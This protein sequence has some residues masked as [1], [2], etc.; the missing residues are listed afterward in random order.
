MPKLVLAALFVLFS[1]AQPQLVPD[2]PHKCED[3]PTWNTP[4]EPFQLFGNSYYV[5]TDGLSAVLVTGDAGH[6]LL[7]AGLS[8]SAA[9]IDANIRK[10]GFKTTDVKLILVSHGHFDHAGGVAALQRFTEA[11]VAASA[12]TADALRRGENTT[13]DPQFGFGQQFNGFP[14][15]ARVQALRDRETVTIGKIQITAHMIPGHAP[16]SAAYTWRSCVPFAPA[17]GTANAECLNMAYVDSVT[18]P[19]A[20]G[21]KYGKPRLELF[22]RSL[23]KVA[24]LPCDIIVS[25]HPSFTRIDEKLRRRAALNGQGPDPFVDPNGCKAYA[26][27]GLKRLEARAAEEAK[28]GR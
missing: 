9:L 17:T 22:R 23:E 25:P 24:G 12:S 14:P 10:L 16:G 27:E 20:P 18:L 19:S 21:F 6:I 26:A 8:Q 11:T 15:V 2:P 7:D 28:A 1:L 13:D 5:G 4:R 3:C